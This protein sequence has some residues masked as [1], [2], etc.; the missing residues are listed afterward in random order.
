MEMD[1]E[2]GLG[3]SFR[4]FA[5]HHYLQVDCWWDQLYQPDKWDMAAYIA[6]TMVVG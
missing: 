5:I 3:C 2:S 1:A 6:P 4:A